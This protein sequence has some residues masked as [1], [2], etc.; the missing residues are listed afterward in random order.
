MGD[1]EIQNKEILKQ[2]DE[3]KI[4]VEHL[5]ELIQRFKF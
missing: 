4:S 1:I 2:A 5:N 3:S